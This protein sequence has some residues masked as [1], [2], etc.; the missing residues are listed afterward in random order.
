MRKAARRLIFA[1]ILLALPLLREAVAA[2]ST[3]EPDGTQASG[4][5]YRIC[6]PG[7]WKGDLVLPTPPDGTSIPRIVNQ[8][9]ETNGR[10]TS[11][12]AGPL[13]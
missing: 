9:G 10:P 8:L 4:A 2:V 11:L 3:C 12:P 6:M 7:T 1:I 13:S 5:V